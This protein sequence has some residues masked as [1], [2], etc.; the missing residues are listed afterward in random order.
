MLSL[1]RIL[2]LVVLADTSRHVVH[3]AARLAR[4]LHAEVILLHVV[5]RFS[6]PAG[7]LER[8]HEITAQALHA[9]IVQRA[10]EDL[11]QALR[12]EL[13]GIA[14][15]SLLLRGDP[16]HEIVKTARDQNV[17]LIVMSTHGEGIFLPL[18]AG[19]SDGESTAR[20]PLPGQALTWRR[21]RCASSP[22]AASPFGRSRS[23]SFSRTWARGP[24]FIIDRSNVPELLNRV[25][26]RTKVDVLVIGHIP[27][28][29]HL[30]DSGNGYGIIR[31]SHI[32][33]LSV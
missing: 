9:Q 12:P 13:D 18:A 10:Q 1:N 16:A 21:G 31:E 25:A 20:K 17:D 19:L 32:P 3:Q 7:I 6:Y 29:S 28:R 4:R 30:G 15:T 27:G 26:E 2:V 5:T 8:G 23:P 11:D 24:R 14:V 22:F 33:V